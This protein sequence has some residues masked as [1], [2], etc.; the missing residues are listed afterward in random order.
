[1]AID[2]PAA[3]RAPAA[4]RR[5]GNAAQRFVSLLDGPRRDVALFRFDDQDRYRWNYRP[6]G[7]EWEGRTVWHEGLRLVNM[8][9]EQQRAALEL[10][11]SGLSERGADR[12]HAIMSLE[13][14]LRET[15][16]FTPFYEHAAR[17]PELYSFAVFGP[18]GGAEPWG[19]RTG[20]HHFGVHFT[21]VDGDVVAPTPLFF[22]ANPAE[23]KH[24]PEVGLRTLPE[25]EDRARELLRLLEPARRRR[26]VVNSVAPG[27]ILTDAY[28]GAEPARVPVGLPFAE[29]SGT[30][31]EHLIALV[32]LYVDRAAG[33]IASA[34][35]RRIEEAGLESITFAWACGEQP[36]EGHYYAVKGPTFVI[37]YDKTQDEANHIH[38]VWRDYTGD[39]GEDVLAMHYR[40]AHAT[41]ARKRSEP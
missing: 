28:R 36:G 24:G 32:R 4:A 19:W 33:E 12:A 39:W 17:D 3:R 41:A 35:W 26:A 14:S 13:R 16:R 7:L 40:E 27:D 2:V 25:E 5:M 38:S 20:G 15:E 23:V 37:E 1:M 10:L 34:S 8:S 30:E 21:I 11:D 22:G 18:P 29:M 6:D 9:R 31:R